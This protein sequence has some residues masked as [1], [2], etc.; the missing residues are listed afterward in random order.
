MD[1]CKTCKKEFKQLQG[2]NRTRCNACNTRIR[3]YRNRIAA[4]QLL[5]G[6]CEHCGFTP[7]SFKE[8]AAI[9]F[10]H[11]NPE[12]KEFTIGLVANKSWNSIVDELKKC[13]LLCD[14]CHSIE[15]VSDI[16]KEFEEEVYNYNGK[17]PIKRL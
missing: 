12:E 1:I 11:K 7:T 10:H 9:Q 13:S 3:R 17:V 4:I 8:L 15:H 16:T 5:G 6:K 14:N 2:K